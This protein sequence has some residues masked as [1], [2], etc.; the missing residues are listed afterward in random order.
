MAN[1][2]ELRR[3]MNHARRTGDGELYQD[4]EAQLADAE[5]QAQIEEPCPPTMRATP[6]ALRRRA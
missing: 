2:K 5:A 6:E 4:L 1:A 3:A